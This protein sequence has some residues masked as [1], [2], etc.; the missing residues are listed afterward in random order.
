M[1]GNLAFDWEDVAYWLGY[2]S[3]RDMLEEWY[4]RQKLTM[5]QIG[6][7]LDI[8]AGTVSKRLRV[9]GIPARKNGP[10]HG[11]PVGPRLPR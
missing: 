7:K 2:P 1:A 9:H 6:N 11:V 3:D 10:K 8:G 5:E 4:L